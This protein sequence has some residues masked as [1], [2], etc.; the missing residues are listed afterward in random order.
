MKQNLGV[1]SAYIGVSISLMIGT[2]VLSNM[3][4]RPKVTLEDFCND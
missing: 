1:I 3:S 2:Q 4:L